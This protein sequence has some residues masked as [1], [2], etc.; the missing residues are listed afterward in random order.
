M[1]DTA[2]L[3][4]TEAL[5]A[6]RAGRLTAVDYRDACLDRIAA[7]EESIRAFA[8]FDPDRVQ[9]SA[10]RGSPLAGIPIDVKDVI[11]T[12][13][14]PSQY[15]SP[16]LGR[17]PAAGRCRLRGRRARRRGGGDGQDR[18]DRIRHPSSGADRQSGQPEAYA[19]RVILRFG[20]RRG[21]GLLPGRLRRQTAGSIIRP[22]AYCGVV[23]FKPT[24][25]T[26]HRAG[27][28]VMS[29]SLDTI[30]VMA[31]SV[32][33][34]ALAMGSMTGLDFG[35]PETRSPRAASRAR[36]GPDGRPGGTGDGRTDRTYGRGLPPCRGKRDAGRPAGGFR[37][38]PMPPMPM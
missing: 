12:A 22:A 11:D 36:D 18:D 27:M 24:F 14:M 20:G 3:T 2:D 19:R 1:T 35:S 17:A 13:D 5:A 29:E 26:M 4:A 30:G 38:R 16:I 31:R 28:K 15:G 25:G 33:D 6:I 32:G 8:W 34:C 21:G 10:A 9:R 23:G 37:R 7:R